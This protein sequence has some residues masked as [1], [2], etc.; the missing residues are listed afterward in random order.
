MIK[1]TD[2][3]VTPLWEV[4]MGYSDEFNKNLLLEINAYYKRTN[5]SVNDSNI[6]LANSL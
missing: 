4:D 1:R 5:A 2:M 3:F 6:W